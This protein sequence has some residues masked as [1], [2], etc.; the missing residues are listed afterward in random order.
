M[1]LRKQKKALPLR[2]KVTPEVEGRKIGNMILGPIPDHLDLGDVI[3]HPNR[4]TIMLVPAMEA[5]LDKYL[6]PVALDR[7]PPETYYAVDKESRTVQS[8]V[9]VDADGIH[10]AWDIDRE[11]RYFL[12]V[13]RPLIAPRSVEV[14]YDQARVI[15]EEGKDAWTQSHKDWLGSLSGHVKGDEPYPDRRTPGRVERPSESLSGPSKTLKPLTSKKPLPKVSKAPVANLPKKRLPLKTAKV[16]DDGI[17]SG[18]GVDQKK[19]NSAAS[20]MADKYADAFPA[21]KRLPIKTAARKTLKR[22]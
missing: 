11:G 22:K 7:C 9:S 4:P 10:L 3:D 6:P 19:L 5:G 17:L 20:N 2:H 14:V 12:R 1:T 8:M 18:A 16:E 21:P 15:R 13:R